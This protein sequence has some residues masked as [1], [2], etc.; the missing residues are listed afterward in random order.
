M[1]SCR[2]RGFCPSC[3]AKRIDDSR[4][5]EIFAREILTML[6]RKEL[7]SP[8]WAERILSWP[9]SG[10]NVHSLVRAKTKIEAERLGKYM[11]RPVLALER[12]T[13]LEPEG[14]VGYRWGRDG[15]GQET[16]V[17]DYLSG[18]GPLLRAL[19][20]RPHLLII[21]SWRLWRIGLNLVVLM[22][23]M[24]AAFACSCAGRP[25]GGRFGLYS[26]RRVCGSMSAAEESGDYFYRPNMLFGL[27]FRIF[28]CH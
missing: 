6:V 10:F 3:H 4:L 11:L 17:M 2:T 26:W 23:S 7:L 19:R 8:E 18:H 21:W 22:A 9:H 20:E 13:F 24:R 5:T 27:D 14:K 16:E 12:L 28:R 25:A 15:A 1:F